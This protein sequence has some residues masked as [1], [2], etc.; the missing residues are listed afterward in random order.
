MSTKRHNNSL[1][2]IAVLM[3][4]DCA[5]PRQQLA[6]KELH[7][8]VG[9][10]NAEMRQLTQHASSI[11]QQNRLNSGSEQGAWLLPASNTAVALKSEAGEL[12]LSLNQIANE[13]SGTHAL[14]HIVS[15]GEKPLPAFSAKIEWGAVDR[16]TG[17]PIQGDGESQ[18]IS[19]QNGLLPRSEVSVPLRLSNITPERLGYVRVH[20]IV[21]QGS[22]QATK[23]R[24]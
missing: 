10:L 1:L 5:A 11:E 6:L 15:S 4:T 21:V 22:P 13:A 2:L 24:P 9:Q 23:A 3:L 14:L 8:Q 20:N 19:V 7:N 18:T 17:N 16:H 12:R